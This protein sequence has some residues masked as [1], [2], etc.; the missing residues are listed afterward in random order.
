[1][2]SLR[3]RCGHRFGVTLIELLVAV[4]IFG[5]VITTAYA[6]LIAGLESR[7]EI[8]ERFDAAQSARFALSLL[9]R[10]LRAAVPLDDDYE[11]LGSDRELEGIVAGTMDFASLSGRAR[12]PGESDRFEVSWFVNQVPEGAGFALFRRADTTPDEEPLAGGVREEIIRGVREFLVEY[13]DGYTW[14]ETWW[15]TSAKQVPVTN[16]P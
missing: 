3:G 12:R 6:C 8:S 15:P 9:A 16:P 11:F 7:R 10:D 4:A 5:G 14:H 1:M 13:Y 2:T